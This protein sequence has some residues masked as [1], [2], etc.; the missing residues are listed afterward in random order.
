MLCAP[1]FRRLPCLLFASAVLLAAAVLGSFPSGAAADIIGDNCVTFTAT[2]TVSGSI[3]TGSAE[4][5]IPAGGYL[6]YTQP[7]SDACEILDSDGHCL[8]RVTLVEYESIGDPAVR[9]RFDVVA[10]ASD[11]TFLITSPTVGFSPIVNPSAYAQASMTVTAGDTAATATGLEAGTKS[12]KAS[13]TN[14][15]NSTTGW[16]YLLNPL[17]AVAE[18]GADSGDRRPTTAPNYETIPATVKSISAEY[19]FTLTAE[20]EA[21]GTS[22]FEVLPEPA[23]LGLMA[24][25]AVVLAARRRRN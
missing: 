9:L 15:S 24:L 21:S 4:F 17:T 16:A 3:R 23:T 13:Y 10:G 7:L 20:N 25:G 22:R 19:S 18:G 8:G 6:L 5:T 1:A 12:F 2:G 14:I 11:T